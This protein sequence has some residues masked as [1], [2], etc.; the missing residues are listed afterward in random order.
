[1][2]HNLGLI[3]VLG[4]KWTTYRKIGEDVVDFLEKENLINNSFSGNT[5]NTKLYG[6]YHLENL[7]RNLTYHDERQILENFKNYIQLKYLMDKP[8]IEKLVFYYGYN[9]TKV[10]DLGAITKTNN[11]LYESLPVLESQIIYS[12]RH[13]MAVK[14]NDIICRR[15]GVGFLDEKLANLLLEKITNIMGKELKWSSSRI[16]KEIEE[17]QKNFKYLL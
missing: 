3:S 7:D 4:G 5:L 1:M 15:I 17:A 14:P 11:K 6:S 8:T 16:K 13:E 9:A 2:T 12:V 10:L